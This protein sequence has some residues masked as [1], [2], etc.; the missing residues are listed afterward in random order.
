MANTATIPLRIVLVA[1]LGL[2][3]AGCKAPAI[4]IGL[5]PSLQELQ[6]S[7]VEADGRT[8]NKIALIDVSGVLF[9]A[10]R[11][12]LLTPGPNPVAQL[13]E[14]LNRAADDDRVKAIVL[15][16]NSPGGGVTASDLM[17]RQV[18]R[19][20][21]TTDKPVVVCLMDV[22]A[23]GGYY[24]ACSGDHLVAHPSTVTGSIGVIAQLVSLKPALDRLGITATTLTS[25]PNKAAGSPLDT[26][27]EDQQA[28]LQTL[29]D[30]FYDDFKTIVREARPNVAEADWDKVT[31]GRVVT[32]RDALKLGLVDA[33]GDLYTAWDTAKSL[34]NIDRAKLVRYHSALRRV[35]SPYA[36]APQANASQTTQINL[37]QFNLNAGLDA[38]FP[39]GFYYLW[40]PATQL[41]TRLP[42]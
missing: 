17:Y 12:G 5:A 31:D 14:Q 33:L 10:D 16:V 19:F 6:E 39:V 42:Q 7:T 8:S 27:T 13:H 3:L 40:S 9:N 2:G 22:A 20:K 34:A 15:R 41:P 29:V 28:V 30:T 11:P 38:N 4:V 37:A 32:G 23:S 26:L 24:L 25:G 1:L 21:Q 36:A 35:T 18:Q